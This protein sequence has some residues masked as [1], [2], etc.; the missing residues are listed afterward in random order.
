MDCSKP[1][2][3][4]LCSEIKHKN[5]STGAI[6]YWGKIDLHFY[7]EKTNNDIFINI[8]K[9][10]IPKIKDLVQDPFIIIRDN[11]SYHC[12]Q[13]TKEWIKKQSKKIRLAT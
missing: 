6:C 5:K 13:Q 8:L 3:W 10:Y 11:A 4:Y 1:K 7:K 9:R 2:L 12:S